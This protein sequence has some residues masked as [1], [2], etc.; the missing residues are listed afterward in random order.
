MSRPWNAGGSTLRPCSTQRRLSGSRRYERGSG[1]RLRSAAV[2]FTEYAW[3][4]VKA[5]PFDDPRVRRALNLA[6]DRARVV[7][8]TGG[9]DAGSPTCQLLSPGLPGYRPICPFTASPSPA[10]AWTKPDRAEGRR[11][12]A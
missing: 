2:P 11:L 7:D 3:L 10:G 8:L 5:P 9:R 4:N 6:V 1:P 12:V